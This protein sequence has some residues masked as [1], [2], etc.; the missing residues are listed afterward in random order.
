MGQTYSKN[1]GQQVDQTL[2]RVA[3]K[4]REEIKGATKLKMAR[5][6]I[7]E[8]G[9]HLEQKSNRQETMKGIGGGKHP[10]VV[11]QSLGERWKGQDTQVT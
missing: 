4:K 3:T 10:A 2:H 8:G 5:R 6:H 1:E 9:N 11:G 7:K